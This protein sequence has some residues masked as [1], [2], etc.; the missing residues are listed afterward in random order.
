MNINKSYTLFAALLL[1][2]AA[3]FG[4]TATTKTTTTVA[5]ADTTT[6]YVLLTSATNVV[7]NGNLFLDGEV[8]QVT[9]GY[10]SGLVVPVRRG[11]VGTVAHTHLTSATVYVFA[12]GLQSRVGILSGPI[13]GTV[14]SGS[15]VRANQ[16]LLPVVHAG[17]NQ[18]FDCLG[19][20]GSANWTATGEQGTVLFCGATTGN[21]TCLNNSGISARSLGGIATLASNSA[22]ISGISPAFT[23]VTSFACVANDLTTRANM[24]QVANTSTSS[25]TITNTTGAA[26]VINYVCSGY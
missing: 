21:G 24:V 12:P 14:P 6:N 19:A 2:T 4:Q 3:L 5:I 7:A 26:D 10:A 25:I 1:S 18:Q 13:P 16:P 20:V 15:C 8:M 23:S 11:A 9:G 22:V 17:L